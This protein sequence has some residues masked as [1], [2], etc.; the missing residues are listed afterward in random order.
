LVNIV[1]GGINNVKRKIW[2]KGR[3]RGEKG[4]KK[5]GQ[6][7]EKKGKRERKKGREKRRGSDRDRII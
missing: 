4:G 6:V 1:G 2:G 7:K 5:I 3:G